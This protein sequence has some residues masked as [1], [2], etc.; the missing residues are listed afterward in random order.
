MAFQDGQGQ[1]L[2]R[3]SQRGVGIDPERMCRRGADRAAMA[4]HD[5]VLA[6][7]GVCEAFDRFAYT[8]QH[9]HH[10]LAARRHFVGGHRPERVRRHD[11]PLG[12]LVVLKSVIV[13]HRL[14]DQARLDR[15]L[16]G[17]IAGRL[18]CLSSVLGA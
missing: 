18:D 3:Q 14:L 8:L 4:H 17:R 15:P 16:G 6:I 5:N 2:D 11:Q 7:V 1:V 9:L 10:A 12:Q 13:A